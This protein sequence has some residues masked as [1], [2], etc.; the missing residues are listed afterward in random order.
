MS[1]AVCLHIYPNW[2]CGSY[3]TCAKAGII[4]A[5]LFHSSNNCLFHHHYTISALHHASF[6]P[7]LCCSPVCLQH[8]HECCCCSQLAKR[9]LLFNI[10]MLLN[11]LLK[12]ATDIACFC[13]LN[14]C[15]PRWTFSSCRSD[16]STSKWLCSRSAPTSI[17]LLLA[18]N[19]IA[20]CCLNVVP[21]WFAVGKQHQQAGEGT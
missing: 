14:V 16:C 4:A 7:Y 21:V 20:V 11:V 3:D 1:A 8:P 9:Q 12:C 10:L 19:H 2:H 15:C 17:P 13:S 5:R 6:M 18:T